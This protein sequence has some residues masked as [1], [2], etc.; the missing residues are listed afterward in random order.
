MLA[1]KM[2]FSSVQ[3]L[4]RVRLF[5][6]PMNRSTPGLPVHKVILVQILHFKGERRESPRG[7]RCKVFHTKE[8]LVLFFSFG[9]ALNL[10]CTLTAFSTM[11]IVNKVT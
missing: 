11:T 8:E 2:K 6:T 4:S 10:R 9:R 1:G 3:L 5:A 7:L